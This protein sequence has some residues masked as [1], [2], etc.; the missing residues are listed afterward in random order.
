MS[1]AGDAG[2]AVVAAADDAD[3]PLATILAGRALALRDAPIPEAV[4]AAAR[5]HLLDA[6]GV[7]LAGGAA[8]TSPLGAG[9]L[10]L[11]AGDGTVVGRTDRLAPASAALANGTLMHSMEFDDTH[12]P[13]VMHGSAVIVPAAL[14]VGERER[15]SGDALLR[16]VVAGWETLVL[17]GLA[18]PGGLQAAGFQTVAAAGP[19]GAAVSAALLTAADEALLVRA[20]GIAGSQASGTFAF[21]SDASTV[22]AMHAGWAAHSGVLANDLAAVGVTGPAAVFEDRFGFFASYARDPEAPA[23]LRDLLP[24]LGTEWALPEA[25]F[26]RYPCCHYI[27]PFLEI[28]ETLRSEGLRPDQVADVVC[29]VPTGA[30]PIVCEPWDRKL[31]PGS[32]HDARWSLPVCLAQVL[33][34]GRLRSADVEGIASDA[35]VLGLA[36]RIRW[37]P[38]EDSGFP[39]RFPADLT[40]RRADGAERRIVVDDVRGTPQRPLAAAEIRAKFDQNA[41]PVV[42]E[43][44]AGR[45][46]A[47][48]AALPG[49]DDVRDLTALLGAPVAERP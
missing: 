10:R 5:D 38:W 32:D 23:R 36:A 47:A 29:R 25:A 31:A 14:A 33:L 28:A 34:R 39:A 22:K 4:L 18:S 6:I 24:R 1:T 2:T 30:A 41:V 44:R 40:V 7:G 49:L 37:E 35:E 11:G 19:F 45:I 16:S 21:L 9:L 20:L 3:A 12:V 17:L 8:S 15:A 27:H 46:A 26:K 42:G 43:D 48:V 13:S